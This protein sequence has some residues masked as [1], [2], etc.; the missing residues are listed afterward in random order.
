MPIVPLIILILS[1]ITTSSTRHYMR[2]HP[3]KREAQIT[4]RF[5]VITHILG[6]IGIITAI[7]MAINHG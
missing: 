3:V 4:I 1:I 2:T 7:I 6:W 5:M